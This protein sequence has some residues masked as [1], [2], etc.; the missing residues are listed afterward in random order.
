MDIDRTSATSGGPAAAAVAASSAHE[1]PWPAFAAGTAVAVLVVL[2]CWA[3]L[4]P[5]LDSDEAY[6]WWW[7][8]H[9]QPGFYDHPPMVA[10]WIRVSTALFGDGAFAVRLPTLLASLMASA[11]LYALA[12]ALFRD[13]RIGLAAAFWF[14][15][16]PLTGLL[17]TMMWPD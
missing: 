16:M 3:A 10:Y 4:V 9:L 6:Y 7:S 12:V 15:A 2:R 8:Q 13:R 17:S 5:E 11:L 14:N 1:L